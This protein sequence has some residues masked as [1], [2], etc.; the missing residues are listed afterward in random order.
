M[1]QLYCKSKFFKDK[2]LYLVRCYCG[3]FWC[4]VQPSEG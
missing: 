3:Y 4:E 2:S 1:M